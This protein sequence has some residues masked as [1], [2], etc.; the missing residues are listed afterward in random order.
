MQVVISQP[1]YLPALN[2]LQRLYFADCFVILDLVQRQARGWEN[3]NQLLLPTPQWLT[4]P[5]ASSS[6]ARLMDAVVD[7]L[8]WVESH[9][10]KIKEHYRQAPFFSSIALDAFYQL[11]SNLSVQGGISFV[12]LAISLM[13]NACA[14]LEF[15]PNLVLA[16]QIVSKEEVVTGPRLLRRLCEGIGGVKQ[17]VSG[18]NGRDYGVCEA[19]YGTGIKAAFHSYQ[20]PLYFHGPSFVPYMGF[21]DA[22]FFCG[23]EWVMAHV[24][25]RPVLEMCP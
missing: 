17:Y 24:R 20:H 16:S 13:S 9:K 14:L 6:R 11:P 23:P 25:E 12:Q 8:D 2:Y 7:G 10:A 21:L 19:F 22:L 15:H 5:I 1:R 3:R 18:P 4:I